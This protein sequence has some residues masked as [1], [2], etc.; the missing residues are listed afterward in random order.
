MFIKKFIPIVILLFLSV[1]CTSLKAQEQKTLKLAS[2]LQS[3]MVIQQNKPF[4]V[5]GWAP[6]GETVTIQGDWMKTPVN[7]VAEGANKFLGIIP[8]PSVKSG[9]FTPHR[10]TVSSGGETI[11]LNNL[12]IG[13]TWI[14][15]GQSN[16]QFS[17]G[18]TIDSA[19]EVPKAN[20]PNI[21]LFSGGLNFSNEPL[22]SISGTWKE[23][24]PETVRRFSAVAYHFGREL[25]QTLN[26]PVGIIFTG[27]GASAAQAYVPREVLAAD[28]MLNRVYLQPYLTSPKSKERLTGDFSFE[29]VT[30]PFLLYNAI[31]HPFTNL[32]IKGFTWYQG[33]ANRNERES[34]TRLTQALIQSW[35]KAFGQGNLPFYYVQIAPFWYDNPDT[36][37]A[38]LAFFQ[39]AQK[40]VSQLSNTAMVVT[41]DVGAAKDLHPKNKKP[42]GMR[43]AKTALNRDYGM[44]DVAY[45]GPQYHHAAFEKAKAIVHFQPETVKSGLTTNNG[46]APLH[47]TMAGADKIF[48]PATAKITGNSIELTSPRV[49][50]PVAVRYAFTNSAVTNLQNGEGIPAVPFRTDNWAEGIKR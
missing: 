47:F 48:Y 15:S 18:E 16:M 25:H 33:E 30:R 35:R 50:N 4:K 5:W 21:R 1:A 14:C 43:L 22:D 38:E 17:M 27:I 44:L 46:G 26:V 36:T 20:F 34:Y 37:A 29:K 2:I 6:A 39:E 40:N 45:Q 10:L 28:T 32:S 13:E 11:A 24:T 42:I 7:V 23:C 41:M 3:N 8:V 9:D 19:Q 49:K 12:L 31:I